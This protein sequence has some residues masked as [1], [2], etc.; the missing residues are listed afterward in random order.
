M[1]QARIPA[2]LVLLSLALLSRA[3]DWPQ[4]RGPD[5]SEVS[6]ETGLLR[7]WPAGGPE[8]LWLFDKGGIGFSGPAVVKGTLFTMGGRDGTEYLIALDAATGAERW[9]AAIGSLYANNWGDGPRGTPTVNADRVYAMG[10]QGALVCVEAASGKTLWTKTMRDL[11]GGVPAWGYAESVLVD[12]DRVICTPG[13]RQ[14]AMAA[15]NK[16]TGEVLWRSS[17]FTEGAQYS[18]PIVVVHDSLRQYIQLTMKKLV[19]VA[20][21]SGRVVWQT[22]WPGRVAVIPTPIHHEGHVYVTSGYNVGCSLVWLGK[23][24]DAAPVYHNQN[25]I[26]Q[27]GGALLYQGHVYGYSDRHGWTCQNFKTG[28]IAWSA[29]EL[30]KGAVFCADGMLYCVSEGDGMV[31]LATAS[32][33]GWEEKGRFRL[34]PQS[35]QR[36]AKAKIWTHPVVA[37]G[38][39]YLRDQEYI[40]CY[41]VKAAV[42]AK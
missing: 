5:R 16:D 12:G 4:W 41:A 11:G 31:A 39:L 7:T 37:N 8:R 42:K 6:M 23:G 34:E 40:S 13:G 15:L 19:G 27:H 29:K 21:D 33:G 30:G 24:G 35:K 3:E 20:A 26:N 18:S 17:D 25:M 9:A 2:V 28:E 10:G 36:K 22:D 38:R 14:G 32:P 1:D